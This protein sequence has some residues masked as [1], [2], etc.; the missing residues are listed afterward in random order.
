MRRRVILATVKYDEGTTVTSNDGRFKLKLTGK[1][2]FREDTTNPDEGSATSHFF[3]ARGRIELE[4]FVFSENTGYKLNYAVADQGASPIRDIYLNQKIAT[5]WV[6]VRFGQYKTPL[7]RQAIMSDFALEMPE[8]SELVNFEQANRD[9][10]VMIHNGFEESPDGFEYEIGI[11]N[12]ALNAEP[13]T[14]ATTTC[15]PEM[16]MMTISCTSTSKL[17]SNVPTDWEPAFI[18]RVGW[19]YGGIKGYQEADWRAGRC[20]SRSGWRTGRT[21]R[22]SPGWTMRSMPTPS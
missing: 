17:P 14:P 21:C 15:T 5:R 8:T 16:M 12:G 7:A 9:M 19:N 20:A 6:Q 2:Q 1:F 13:N 11:F 22:T 10:G 4:G 18:G 3:I